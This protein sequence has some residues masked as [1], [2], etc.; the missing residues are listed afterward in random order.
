MEEK[1]VILKDLLLKPRPTSLRY[2]LIFSRN[3]QPSCCTASTYTRGR[4]NRSGRWNPMNP[5]HSSLILIAGKRSRSSLAWIRTTPS[6]SWRN[7]QKQSRKTFFPTS[8]TRRLRSSQTCSRIP[9]EYGRRADVAGG[10]RSLF[11]HDLP[12]GDPHPSYH[13]YRCPWIRLLVPVSE[14]LLNRTQM[15]RGFFKIC[16]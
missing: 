7:S 6:T 2:F 13:R 15:R 4:P 16:N 3:R 14:T 10:N 8:A 12:G 11:G 1:K 9:P 5:Q